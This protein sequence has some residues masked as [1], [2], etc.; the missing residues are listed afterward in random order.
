[1][2]K[3]DEFGSQGALEILRQWLDYEGWY[4]RQKQSW[5]QIL[6]MQLI[7]AM[8]PPGGG[9]SVISERIQSR[10]NVINFTFPANSQV[11]RIFKIILSARELR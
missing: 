7:C 2:P 3:K 10:F 9:R 11:Q 6:D 1:M 5:R 8:G 4:D